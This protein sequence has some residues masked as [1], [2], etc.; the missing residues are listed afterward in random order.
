M[1]KKLGIL[2]LIVVAFILL[3]NS[4]LMPWYVKHSNLVKVPNVTGLNFLDAKKVLEQSGLDV[5]QGDIRYDESKPIGFVMDQAPAVDEM[6][7]NGRR[8]YLTVCGGEQLMEVPRLI[9]KSERD[10][11]FS[12]VQRNLQ[13]GEI[14]KKF[15]TEQ[16]EDFVISQVIQPGSKVKKGTKV[17][18]IISNGQLLGSIIVPDVVGKKLADARKLIE[19]KKLKLGKITYQS[20]DLPVGQVIDQYPK[21][22]KSAKDNTPV[23]LFIA[24]KKTENE[25]AAEDIG[26]NDKEPKEKK[27]TDDKEK[28]EKTKPADEQPKDKTS[29]KSKEKVND[30]AKEKT[31]DKPKEKTQ[32]KSK[33]KTN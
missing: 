4:I 19:D 12:L 16:P 30:K 25:K 2:S 29:D 9:G 18:L 27:T 20:S 23:D 32:D 6:V 15:T 13:V 3:F 11:R 7:K 26:D 10:A 14:V 33:E 31:P 17:D 22:D 24:K 21:K 5:K 8:V 28:K 1:L